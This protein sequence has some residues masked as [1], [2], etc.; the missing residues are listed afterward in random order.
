MRIKI[1]NPHRLGN[2]SL[3]KNFG[4]YLIS[5]KGEG[6][7]PTGIEWYKFELQH[8][9]YRTNNKSAILLIHKE[10]KEVYDP[11]NREF[12][13]MV[14]LTYVS[15]RGKEVNNSISMNTFRVMDWLLDSIN[16]TM[17]AVV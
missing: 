7:N 2:R 6:E 4:D 13:M 1:T 15:N 9:E 12:H 5:F 10:T 3:L 14:N 11:Y 16:T 17:G 8:R